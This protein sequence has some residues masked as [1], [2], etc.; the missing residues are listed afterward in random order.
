[1]FHLSRLKLK[2]TFYVLILA[3][4]FVL[5]AMP[6]MSTKFSKASL[7]LCSDLGY[8]LD[9]GTGAPDTDVAASTA[10]G[11]KW[12]IQELFQ[13]GAKY[14]VYLGETGSKTKDSWIL[15]NTKQ[16]PRGKGYDGWDDSSV[17]A[18]LQS[19]RSGYKCY[20]GG[21]TSAVG[22]MF[23]ALSDWILDLGNSIVEQLYNP[24]FICAGGT[25]TNDCVINLV[26]VIGGSSDSANNGS[27]IS[28]LYTGIYA[29][30]VSFAFLFVA[31]W[32]IYKGLIKREIRASFSGLLWSIIIFFIG[33]ISMLHP[34]TLASAP[35]QANSLIGSCVIGAM[36]GQ[37]CMDGS[38][39]APST[40]TGTD[41][42]SYASGAHKNQTAQL[43]VNGLGCAIW[44]SFVLNPWSTAEF[45]RPY[46][47]LYIGHTPRNGHK[48]KIAKDIKNPNDYCIHMTS[49]KSA[50]DQ[51]NGVTLTHG[52]QI[53]NLAAYQLYL[54]SNINDTQ[55]TSKQK[56][57]S[58]TIDDR[59]YNI[60]IPVSKDPTA[61][62]AWSPRT[63][64]GT[65]RIMSS[66]VSFIS[67]VIAMVSLV[68]FAFWGL[69]YEFAG[70]LLM[71]FAP[72][73]FLVGVVPGNGK[74]IFLGWIESVVSSILKYLASALFVIIALTMYAGIVSNAKSAGGAFIGIL[75][76]VGVM[77]TYRKEI[78]NLLGQAN[79]GGKRVSNALGEKIKE[80][81]HK[82]NE[83]GKM[84]LGAGVG[85]MW[86]GRG[87]GQSPF[88]N[89]AHGAAS[90][91]TRRLKRDNTMLGAS[92]RQGSIARSQKKADTARDKENEAKIRNEERKRLEKEQKQK[93]KDNNDN[94]KPQNQD[95]KPNNPND[96]NDNGG[97][98]NIPNPTSHE[99]TTKAKGTNSNNRPQKRADLTN[100]QKSKDV[101]SMPK[102]TDANNVS[103]D[104]KPK[105]TETPKTK[106]PKTSHNTKNS[107]KPLTNNKGNGN[108]AV[109]HQQ[110]E[111]PQPHVDNQPINTKSE[112]QHPGKL[113]DLNNLDTQTSNKNVKDAKQKVDK[114]VKDVK[115]KTS[116]VNDK[117]DDANKS[118][119]ND[120]DKHDN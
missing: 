108:N 98:G 35:Q 51:E 40:I 71:A 5:V 22:N 43:A 103:H 69:I 54:N 31:I 86:G 15:Y 67:A 20:T 74:R 65:L 78:V 95:P 97:S 49:D 106:Q 94:N 90:G 81:A 72:L 101:N 77:I 45:G 1:M 33:V 102:N 59:Y 82:T 6:T 39:Q 21:I 105:T 96:G 56:H 25:N 53:C 11:R 88:K 41:C 115:D 91:A 63:G 47:N 48:W 117:I 60:I 70:T 73:F 114:Q 24:T 107:Q 68:I 109:T 3:L 10:S 4:S 104:N 75:I 30:L 119:K 84:S 58:Q 80:K 116:A 118:T 12:T 55:N 19:A 14:S 29:P 89:F 32:L 50:S 27:L 44:K 17:Q 34:L 64:G 110:R 9:S 93:G 52:P 100:S 79:F 112:Q 2:R 38:T 83:V 37:N 87:N 13:N 61:W 92:I 42:D 18:K 16:D 99:N 113:P 76:M 111:H 8:N 57:P 23:Y 26:G 7:G 36:N 62:N 66:M 85:A 28:N 120:T 46:S